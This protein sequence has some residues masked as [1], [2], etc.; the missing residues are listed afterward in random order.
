MLVV[1]TS[2]RIAPLTAMISGMRKLP[3]ISMSWP[4]ETITSLP[5]A[6]ARRAMTVAAAL[7]LTAV[8]DSAPVSAAEPVADRLRPRRALAGFEIEFEVEVAAGG[9]GRGLGRRLGERRP[10]EVGVQD[11]AG[12]VDDG[13]Q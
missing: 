10:A 5:A 12:G 4:R 13:P 3:P 1:P 9:V 8:A 7:L 6:S 11:D 2:R